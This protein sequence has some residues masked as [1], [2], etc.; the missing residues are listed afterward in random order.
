[1]SDSSENAGVQTLRER[2]W[3]VYRAYVEHENELIHNRTTW[4]I[5]IQSFLVLAFGFAYQKYFEVVAKCDGIPIDKTQGDIGQLKF[6]LRVLAYVG[7]TVSSVAFLSI[8]ASM[9]AVSGLKKKWHDLQH[10]DSYRYLQ[11][12]DSY[13]PPLTGGSYYELRICGKTKQ[14]P[15]AVLLGRIATLSLP[16]SFVIAWIVIIVWLF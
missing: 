15:L 16:V 1:M 10:K 3:N 4:L 7:I 9:L 12:K 8:V 6:F 13:L 5:T 2:V 14:I 11:L